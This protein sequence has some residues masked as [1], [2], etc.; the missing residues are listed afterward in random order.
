MSVSGETDVPPSSAAEEAPGSPGG[1]H[2]V[3]VG[4]HAAE[5]DAAGFDAY[6]VTAVMRRE[7][8]AR[9]APDLAARFARIALLDL[10][11]SDDLE[12][13]DR[14]IDPIVE[15]VTGLA[16]EFGGP[17]AIVGLYE[18]TTLPAARLR[19]HFRVP[20]TDVW[21]ATLCRDKVRM[22]QA[23][24][25]AG[26]RVP[27]F[28]AVDPSTSRKDLERF[29]R[30]IPGR[31]VLK[32]R[33]QAASFGVRILDN[34]A[35]LLA[36]AADDRIEPG[37]EAEEFIEGTILH[38]DGIV[39]DGAIR[40][41]SA[42][43][44]LDSCYSFQYEGVPLASVTLDD[45]V[46]A[47]RTFQF[48][49]DVLRGL[50]LT[51]SAFHLEAFLTPGGELVFLEIG[52]RFGGA[53]VPDQ[54]RVIYGVDLRR[55][56]VLACTGGLSELA[57]PATALDHPAA[58]ASGWLYMPLTEKRHCRVTCIHGQDDLPASV[59]RADIPAVGDVLNDSPD[60]WPAAG[61]FLLRGTSTAAV[62]QD[63]T[64]IAETYSVIVR[65]GD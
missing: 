57:V 40:W 49:A 61:R 10:P 13:Y 36:L 32:P 55:E 41:F 34:A 7:S 58:G 21:T 50:R 48:T 59:V 19:E 53:G 15:L 44:Y 30:T 51:D 1:P 20:G 62:E 22:K 27:R 56:S 18:H 9:L 26:M 38:L 39:R 5:A 3:H 17:A 23:L 35:G 42:S 8:A 14:A 24:E 25:E 16:G 54:H 65:T 11:D 29:A 52:N 4:F 60:T 63:M 33:S 28:L 47:A 2:V 43:K 31:I 12:A 46:L 6:T 64:K 45:P 37:Y